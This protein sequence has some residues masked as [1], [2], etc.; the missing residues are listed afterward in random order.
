[1]VTPTTTLITKILLGTFG[2]VPA[3]DT[4]VRQTAS[5]ENVVF[6]R[7]SDESI[8]QFACF[9]LDNKSGFC[10]VK[11]ELEKLGKDYPD[12]KLV[13]MYFFNSSYNFDVEKNIQV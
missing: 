3:Y 12:M 11:I 10:D 2:C 4:Y 9:Y 7:L 5:R 8:Y 13:D 1:M 6:S